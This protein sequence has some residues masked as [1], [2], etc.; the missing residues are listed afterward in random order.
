VV[1][2]PIHAFLEPDSRPEVT[3]FPPLRRGNFLADPFGVARDGKIHVFCEEFDHQ[4][5]KGV[6][7]R[8]ELS[9][10]GF[11]SSPIQAL[12]RPF[13]LSYPYLVE[14]NEHT[15]FIPES[16]QAREISL[17]RAD[18]FPERWIK[19]TTLVSDFA[20]VDPTVFFHRGRWWMMCTDQDTGPH[21]KLFVWHAPD[22]AGP[23][24]PHAANPVRVGRNGS[25]P[26][27]TPFVHRGDLYRPAMDCSEIYGKRIIINRVLDLTTTDFH[28]EP[29]CAVGPFSR[30]PYP[31]GLHTLSAV[32]NATLVDGLRLKFEKVEFKLALG[33]ERAGLA[34]KLNGMWHKS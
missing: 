21:E 32:K 2:E 19:V 10:E 4:S 11:S 31:D 9:E 24:E 22:L 5:H 28:E 14:W 20:G 17:Y 34:G 3:W 27:G 30:G 29:V 15:Y 16:H 23:W 12:D 8:L 7:A 26:A 13:H 6:I 33:R 18:R 1:W 25:R